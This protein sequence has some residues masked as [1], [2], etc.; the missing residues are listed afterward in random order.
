MKIAA[1]ITSTVATR[2]FQILIFLFT[3]IALARGL[4]PE[5]R[6]ELGILMLIPGTVVQISMFGLS[7]SQTFL[8]ANHKKGE[9]EGYIGTG[10][11]LHLMQGIASMVAFLA[12]YAA[13]QMVWKDY[14]LSLVLLACSMIPLQFLASGVLHTFVGLQRI[15]LWNLFSIGRS[16]LYLGGIG[17]LWLTDTISVPSVVVVNLAIYAAEVVFGLPFLLKRPFPRITFNSSVLKQFYSFGMRSYAN[18]VIITF[19][20]RAGVYFLGHVDN[21]VQASYFVIGLAM[22]ERL[23]LLPKAINSV[24]F[25]ASARL[26]GEAGDT[27]TGRLIRLN[28]IVFIPMLVV[29]ALAAPFFV[30]L[31]F[32][33]EYAP[34]VP[35]VIIIL[36]AVL[37]LGTENVTM[38]HLSGI[39]KPQLVTLP[40]AL[41]LAICAAGC[42]WLVPEMGAFGAGISM[43][44]GSFALAAA[45]AAVVAR[46]MKKSVWEVFV[47]S[48]DDFRL[49]SDRLGKMWNEKIKKKI[50]GEKRP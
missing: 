3:S 31:L 18:L 17:A 26:K 12:V 40:R 32:G 48:R 34:M 45:L 44:A 29:A 2:V 39:G 10:I 19:F 24:L 9:R 41:A 14:E 7:S 37:F 8:T 5:L 11:I 27:L 13:N 36:P 46:Q 38:A 35:V 43:T 30:P 28:I 22:C 33:E 16:L 6:G 20:Y 49:V 21:P 47:P 1:H 4:K 23:L 25:P 42:L 50:A 15:H